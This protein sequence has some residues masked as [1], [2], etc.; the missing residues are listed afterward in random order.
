MASPPAAVIPIARYIAGFDPLAILAAV[1]FPNDRYDTLIRRDRRARLAALRKQDLDVF[2]SSPE[3]SPA[4]APAPKEEPPIVPVNETSEASSGVD[5]R[6]AESETRTTTQPIIGEQEQRQDH[7]SGPPLALPL[8]PLP[9][10]DKDKPQDKALVDNGIKWTTTLTKIYEQGPDFTFGLTQ[11]V[12]PPVSFSTTKQAQARPLS[13]SSDPALASRLSRHAAALLIQSVARGWLVRIRYSQVRHPDLSNQ[14]WT[15]SSASW[16]DTTASLG[17]GPGRRAL[18]ELGLPDVTESALAAQEALI[19]R[20]AVHCSKSERNHYRAHELRWRAA[21]AEHLLRHD[22]DKQRHASTSTPQPIARRQ[23]SFARTI[24]PPSR[25]PPF[26]PPTFPDFCATLIQSLYK[27]WTLRRKY[28]LARTKQGME[29][30]KLLKEMREQEGKRHERGALEGNREEAARRIQTGWRAY[31]CKKIYRFYRHIIALHAHSPA[32]SLMRILNPR[33]RDLL[34]DPAA[35]VHVRFRLGGDSFPP[36]VYYKV[37]VEGAVCDLGGFAPRD[38]V[39]DVGVKQQ[40]PAVLFNKT[41]HGK[42]G[43]MVTAEHPAAS[44]QNGWYLRTT[45]NGYR[46][47]PSKLLND[48]LRDPVAESTAAAA[49]VSY[50]HVKLVRRREIERKKREKRMEW[51]RRVYGVVVGDLGVGVGGLDRRHTPGS[52]VKRRKSA[53]NSAAGV[54]PVPPDLPEDLVHWTRGLDFDDYSK[55]WYNIGIAGR[56]KRYALTP[57]RVPSDSNLPHVNNSREE[58]DDSKDVKAS[59]SLPPP[60]SGD[61]G[62]ETLGIVGPWEEKPHRFDNDYEGLSGQETGVAFFGG[63]Y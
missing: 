55:R 14:R 29:L 59:M 13:L 51:W 5:R 61:T 45:N 3:L 30:T 21:H 17:P 34:L 28:V 42:G 43:A 31:Y 57:P 52:S 8:P 10:P 2:L 63:M 37:F 44:A 60:P 27:T 58:R 19:Q 54:E 23:A 39:R 24:P 50:H 7:A 35:P 36:Q 62:R 47:V 46:P 12:K 41:P 9:T 25:P 26:F 38:Y 18:G 1:S 49:K 20:Y 56:T 15:G 11:R 33:E 16:P 22:K 32:S 6:E 48:G 4:P 53:G 40:L